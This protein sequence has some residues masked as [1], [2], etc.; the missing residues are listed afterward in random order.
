MLLRRHSRAF[1]PLTRPWPRVMLRPTCAAG[2]SPGLT[3]TTRRSYGDADMNKIL[4]A[5]LITLSA[6][7]MT[8]CGDKDDTAATDDTAAE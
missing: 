4:L 6:L 7:S 3:P 8:A 5:L 1:V 2:P